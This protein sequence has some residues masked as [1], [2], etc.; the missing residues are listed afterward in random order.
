MGQIV[1][2]AVLREDRLD[3]STESRLV[4]SKQFPDDGTDDPHA[5]ARDA[6]VALLE[7]L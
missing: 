2:T 4:A 3:Q 7:E 1:T 6:L 5:F